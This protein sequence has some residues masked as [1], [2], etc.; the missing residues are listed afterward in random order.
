MPAVEDRKINGHINVFIN[1]KSIPLL[2]KQIL[3]KE[4]D[5]V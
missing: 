1:E 2:R 3:E 5:G 4:Q